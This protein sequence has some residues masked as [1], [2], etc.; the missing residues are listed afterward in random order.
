[1][2]WPTASASAIFFSTTALVGRGSMAKVSTRNRAVV[3]PTLC[4]SSISLIAVELMSMPSMALFL[5]RRPNM[6]FS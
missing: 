6:G 3:E 4:D 5:R 2:H 1:M